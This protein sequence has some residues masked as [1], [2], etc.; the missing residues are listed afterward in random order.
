MARTAWCA[1]VHA[2]VGDEDEPNASRRKKGM[3]CCTRTYVRIDERVCMCVCLLIHERLTR[4]CVDGECVQRSV[5]SCRAWSGRERRAVSAPHPESPLETN[6]SYRDEPPLR[7]RA[8]LSLVYLPLSPYRFA[9][10]LSPLF[11]RTPSLVH[12]PSVCVGTTSKKTQ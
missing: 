4:V 12:N 8:L 10:F 6:P 11:R 2:R 7:G 3:R 9:L 1:Y 5:S